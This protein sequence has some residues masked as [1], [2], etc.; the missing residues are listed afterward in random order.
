MTTFTY[1]AAANY[2]HARFLAHELGFGPNEWRYLS[3][4]RP[5]MGATGDHSEILWYETAYQHPRYHEL[6][7]AA[8][9]RGLEVPC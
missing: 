8:R 9:A 2:S 3:D 4:E 1:I 7:R 5:L 6:V